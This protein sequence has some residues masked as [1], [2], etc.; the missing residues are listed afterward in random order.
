MIVGYLG[1]N[2]GR[3]MQVLRANIR[4]K[5]VWCCLKYL[6][7]ESHQLALGECKHVHRRIIHMRLND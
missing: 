4:R 5:R 2:V 6:F 3:E 1:A 7:G